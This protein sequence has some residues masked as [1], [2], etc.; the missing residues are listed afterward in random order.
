M[1]RLTTN[2]ESDCLFRMHVY[3]RTWSMSKKDKE[4]I[5]KTQ[6]APERVIL[7]INKR[8]KVWLIWIKQ[9]LKKNKNIIRKIR[10]LKWKWAGHV[11]RLRDD[12]WT[13]RVTFWFLKQYK[14]KVRK[15]TRR[16]TGDLNI[17]LRHKM[18]HRIT[19]DCKEWGQTQE[20]FALEQ[21]LG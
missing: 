17:I 12:R 19:T 21:G 10:R 16:W 2:E 5:Q 14:T 15:Q 13:Y 7:G 9:K 18:N 11:G 8:D 4:K 1:S 3:E 20:A 6:T